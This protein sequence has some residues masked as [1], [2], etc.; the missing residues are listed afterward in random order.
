MRKKTQPHFWS[1]SGGSISAL[2]TFPS[3]RGS[4]FIATRT[5]AADTMPS[6]YLPRVLWRRYSNAWWP[7]SEYARA[8]RSERLAIRTS[9]TRRLALERSSGCRG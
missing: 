3:T 2:Y 9:R 8:C 6:L 5:S 7:W 4:S 1:D